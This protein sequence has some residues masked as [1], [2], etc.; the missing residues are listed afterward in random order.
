MKKPDISTRL[1]EELNNCNI[2]YL[3]Y[4]EQRIEF[5]N[6]EQRVKEEQMFIELDDV[7]ELNRICNKKDIKLMLY[8]TF[9]YKR[10]INI[11]ELKAMT[12]KY[13]DINKIYK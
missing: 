13:G 2:I 12:K 9:V 1:K 11:E 10:T 7:E 6:E 8:W 3:S 4:D 5:W